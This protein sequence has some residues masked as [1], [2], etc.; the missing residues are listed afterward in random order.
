MPVQKFN[1][2]SDLPTKLP[3]EQFDQLLQGN[4]FRMERILSTGQITPSGQW[5][6]QPQDEWVMLLAGSARLELA[7]GGEIISLTPGEALLIPAGCKHRVSWTEPE[8]VTVWL[9]LHFQGEDG[10]APGRL[11]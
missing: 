6:D 9:A 11:G 7:L 3:A 1:L 8:K 5:Y 10:E 4:S 2:L